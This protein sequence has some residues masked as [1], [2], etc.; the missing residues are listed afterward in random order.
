MPVTPHRRMRKERD[1][2]GEKSLPAEAYYGIQTQRAVEN[3]SISGQRAH[4]TFIEA[5]IMIKRAAAVSNMET[6]ALDKRIGRAIVRAADEVL[7]GKLRDQFVVDIFQAGA[8]TSFNMNVNEVLANRAIEI[9]GGRK[10]DYS[11]VH[12]NDHVNMSQSTN[13]TFPTAMRVSALL[14][15]DDLLKSLDGLAGAFEAKG[16]EFDHILKSGRTHLMDAVPIRLG[17]E[18]TAYSRTLKKLSRYIRSTA[19]ELCELGI[20]GTA[21][22]TGINTHP[23]YRT[24]VIRELRRL[25]GLP[26]IAAPDMREAMQSNFPIAA[27][28]SALRLLA[29]EIIRISGDLRLLGSG[30]ATG[31]GEI[32]LP[33]VQPGSSIMPG[34]VNP[35][36]AEMI[37]MVA[38]QVIGNDLAISMAVQAGQLELN[39]MMPVM[40]SN[41]LSSIEILTNAMRAFS[42]RCVR[43]ITADEERCRDYAQKSTGLATALAPYI[44]YHRAAEVARKA[45][46]EG[47]AIPDVV[48]EM[49]LIPEKDFIRI[50]DPYHMTG[51]RRRKP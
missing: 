35:V 19:N 22:G 15:I 30:P 9:L 37:S 38:Y 24:K 17:Q 23:L 12:P 1:F 40:I 11:I 20:G 4:P 31:L 27:L 6:K 49:G 34:K 5:Y 50:L 16:K 47:K 36:M 28:S 3:F 41:L 18:F 45:L 25:T 51:K 46:T 7:R 13:D 43:G 21:V 44:G 29:L 33:A 8:G 39:V 10:G 48:R 14:T 26:L 2:L 32:D 42:E